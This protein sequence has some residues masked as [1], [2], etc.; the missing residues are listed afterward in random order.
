MSYRL[1]RKLSEANFF[2]WQFEQN[3][4]LPYCKN[5]PLLRKCLT[6]QYDALGLTRFEC[7]DRLEWE[8]NGNI[9]NQKHINPE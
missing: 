6:P 1:S 7:F 2:E 9:R 5:C 3:G 4:M 8:R